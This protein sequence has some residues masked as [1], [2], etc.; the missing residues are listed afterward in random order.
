[1]EQ[2][3][4][5]KQ[6]KKKAVTELTII[7]PLDGEPTKDHPQEYWLMW[8]GASYVKSVESIV[9]MGR[10]LAKFRDGFPYGEWE[11]AITTHLRIS[12][13]TVIK[14]IAIGENK[15]LANPSIWKD[16]PAQWTV[17]Y[18]LSLVEEKVLKAKIKELNPGIGLSDVLA[19][20]KGK[21]SS[22]KVEEDE[23][24]DPE[25]KA[26]RAPLNEWDKLSGEI[27]RFIS[28]VDQ[29]AK[30]IVKKARASG[31][32]EKELLKAEV[33]DAFKQQMD[34]GFNKRLDAIVL[35]IKGPPIHPGTHVG[36]RG[37][38]RTE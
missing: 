1:M 37:K 3:H 17:L 27:E 14:L 10:R 16:L 19:L 28:T 6:A 21:A 9:E 7:P 20:K 25:P 31:E 4:I 13:S 35:G 11:K 12:S 22:T 34:D 38:R 26:R 24:E 5:M 32:T 29:I 15:V 30:E 2:A 8:V 23:D 33:I 18:A 36:P